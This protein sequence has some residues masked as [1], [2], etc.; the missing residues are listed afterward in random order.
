MVSPTPLTELR[1]ALLTPRFP[2]DTGGVA[3]AAARLAHGLQAHIGLDIVVLSTGA[4][5]VDPAPSSSLTLSRLQASSH[6]EAQAR[7]FDLLRDRGPY[8]LVHAVY[9]SLT[10][11]VARFYARYA[12]IPL[13]VSVRGN[14]LLRDGFRPEFQLG[15]C[16]ALRGADVVVGVSR[17]LC[18]MAEA[19]GASRTR[20]I[21][22]GVDTDRFRYLDQRR[23]LCDTLGIDPVAPLIA[24][25]GEARHKKGLSIVLAALARLRPVWP[26]ARLLLIGGVRQDAVP[27]LDAWC[28]D[29]PAAAEALIQVPWMEQERLAAYYSLA[30]VVW[31]PSVSDGLPNA[32]L[33]AM[34]C[35]RPIVATAVGGILDIAAGSPLT[36]WLLGSPRA[37]ELAA[38]TDRLLRLDE[39]S[40]RAL[41]RAYRDHVARRFRA[42]AE[43]AAYRELYAEL[44]GQSAHGTAAFDQEVR[45]HD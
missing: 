12:R 13:L 32:V 9:P 35:E 1:V 26:G 19:L 6:A 25:V 45:P 38:L 7:C 8:R 33:E 34:A 2:P 14:D 44:T 40:R 20:W 37:L 42:D 17:E 39:G 22:N 5:A 24:L 4:L 15:L 31:Q 16:E 18:R 10:G 27:A 28:R 29:N 23:S 3:A 36:E 21:P 41:G 11:F 43:V 30:D